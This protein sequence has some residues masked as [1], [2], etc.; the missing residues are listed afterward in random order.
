MIPAD[1]LADTL[2]ERTLELV[3]IAS[4][5]GEEALLADH[6]ERFLADRTS[7]AHLARHGN[8]LVAR[9]GD[10]R[11]LV[12]LGGHLDTVPANQNP[13]PAVDESN[14]VGLGA[15]DMKGAL[16]VMLAL[17]EEWP[18]ATAGSLGL[19][20]THLGSLKAFAASEVGIRNASMV[21][22]PKS[23]QPTY[24]LAVG[25]P[26]ESHAIEMARNLGFPEERVKRAEELLPQEERDIK[27]LL[28]ELNSER[29]RLAAGNEELERKV[30][31]ASRLED[32]RRERLQHLLLQYHKF[33]QS[34][35]R[36]GY[37]QNYSCRIIVF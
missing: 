26:G 5:S 8:A 4:P 10:R 3:R 16:A 34:T 14:V 22:D 28:A 9:Y 20:T 30:A 1:R 18:G 36:P 24:G 25:I 33:P 11:P 27:E 32:E 29:R 37:S 23:Q 17:A 12:V 21:F 15:T 19:V 6:V 7:P 31:E 13:G 35:R 2:A